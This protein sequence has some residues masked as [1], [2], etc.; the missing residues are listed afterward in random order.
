MKSLRLLLVVVLVSFFSS[1]A[2]SQTDKEKAMKKTLEAIKLMDKGKIKESLK[3]L[4]EAEKL[5]PDEP[6]IKYEKAYAYYISQEY[7]KAIKVLKKLVNHKNA[8][9]RYYQLLGNSYDLVK[10]KK[11]AIE[12]YDEGLEK[13]PN[14]GKLYFEKGVVLLFDKKYNG[15]LN[16][17][18]NGIKVDP[19]HPSNYYWA[20]KIYCSSSE[21]IWGV[22]YGE[23]FM[24]IERNSK[25]TV[26]MS[27]ILYDT[28]VE[29]IE[30]TDSGANVSFSKVNTVSIGDNLGNIKLPF[31]ILVYEPTMALAVATAIN[32]ENKGKVN[33]KSLSSTRA[34]FVEL[35]FGN[36][37]NE[38][39]TNILFDYQKKL[40]DKGYL[41]AY[42]HWIMM[43]GDEDAFDAWYEKNKEKY[44][45]F[46]DWF[47]S[48]PLKVDDENKFHRS[49]Y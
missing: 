44:N 15:A 24:N 35:F 1:S 29:A 18:E 30:V 37:K 10:Q 3:L 12:T 26:E 25:R 42:N 8:N 16:S 45:A 33:L 21:K 43:K 9:D 41:E 4:G 22:L 13:F 40:A 38:K 34:K 48:N 7:K 39:Y 23:L 47:N 11:K 32:I 28:Y 2:Y 27:K 49:Q 46:A 17:F 6:D 31:G 36:E 14:S 5:D 20:A 19:K